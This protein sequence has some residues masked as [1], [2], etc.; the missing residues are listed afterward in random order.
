MI[1]IVEKIE[2]KKS[3]VILLA[4][5]IFPSLIAMCVLVFMSSISIRKGS[6]SLIVKT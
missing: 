3:S 4:V 6:L 1:D 2:F 5:F